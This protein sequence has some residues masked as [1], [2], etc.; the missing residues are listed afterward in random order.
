MVGISWRKINSKHKSIDLD[1]IRR[2]AGNDQ[3]NAAAL[4]WAAINHRIIST[5]RNII[6]SLLL[7]LLLLLLRRRGVSLQ[8]GVTFEYLHFIG[9]CRRI[10]G[11]PRGFFYL[12]KVVDINIRHESMT[13][14]LH[15]WIRQQFMLKFR[16]AP[17]ISS[18]FRLPSVFDLLG[19]EFGAQIGFRN[20]GLRYLPTFGNPGVNEL[21]SVRVSFKMSMTQ[22]LTAFKALL[23][24]LAPR[25]GS[26]TLDLNY[27]TASNWL[28]FEL[29][30][31][32]GFCN[33]QMPF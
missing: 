2:I 1:L 8:H 14:A 7:L 13:K 5:K 4:L 26:A 6:I 27:S 18:A 24:N 32:I 31:S 16:W 10:H 23:L 20:L 21:D 33:L 11:I 29:S 30:G 12:F 3:W 28:I 22:S 17:L 25:S 9:F 15:I 19:F